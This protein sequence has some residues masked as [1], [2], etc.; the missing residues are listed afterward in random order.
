MNKGLIMLM[1]LDGFGISNYEEGNAI[2]EANT[3][4]IDYLLNTYPNSKI[5][6]SGVIK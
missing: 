5:S 4:N 6:A 1:I 2:K 3:P